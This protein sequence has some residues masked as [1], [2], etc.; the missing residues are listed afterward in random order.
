MTTNRS[1]WEILVPTI[2]NDGKPYRLRYHKVWDKK[3]KEISGGLTIMPKAKGQWISPSGTLFVEQMIPVRILATKSEIE[4][5]VD[6]TIKY[7]SQEAVL[8]YKVS[9][10]VIL[11]YASPKKEK[12]KLVANSVIAT[13]QIEK[14]LNSNINDLESCICPSWMGGDCGGRGKNCYSR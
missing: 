3:V 14:P 4:S 9:D 10:D 7:Y 11:K 6:L 2:R 5:I 13:T 8:A 1:L 12:T